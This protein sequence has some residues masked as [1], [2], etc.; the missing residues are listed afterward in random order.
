M[1]TPEPL[2]P[3]EP[4]Y[5]PQAWADYTFAELGWWVHLLAQR[6]THRENPEKRRKDLHDARN[7][8]AIMNTKLADLEMDAW[9]TQP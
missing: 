6:S 2:K 9:G 8:L 7:Y 5:K 1:D 4:D 3:H